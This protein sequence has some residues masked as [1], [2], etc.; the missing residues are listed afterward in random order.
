[1]PRATLL[2]TN[3]VTLGELLSN[4][5][6][7]A[8]PA[9]QR[10]YSWT[11][12]HWEDLWQDIAAL[13]R[14]ELPH[15]MGAVVLQYGPEAFTVIDGQ[16]RLATLS[17]LALA[18]LRVL[19][20]LR[21]KESEAETI[22][23][24][25]RLLREQFVGGK[26]PASLRYSSKLQLNE[27]DNA[28]YQ[29]VLVQQKEPLNLRKLTTSERLLWNALAFFEKRL[30][31]S[32]ASRLQ[33]EA[34]A[35]FLN[36]L[37][38]GRL[39]FIEIRVEDDLSA[40]T[41][42][43]TLNARG[44]ELTEAD[45]LKN[46][47]FSLLA[48]SRLDLEHAREQWSRISRQVS[49]RD[50]PL[51]LRHYLNS[52]QRYVRRE[53]VFRALKEKVAA[54]EQ[55]FDLLQDLERLAYLY[56]ALDAPDDELWLDY[57]GCREEVRLLGLFRVSQYKP[58]ALACHE[59]LGAEDF[60]GVLHACVIVSF[61]FNVVGRRSTHILEEVFNEAAMKVASGEIRD[62]RGVRVALRNAY[63]PDEEFRTDFESA[64]FPARQH[65]KLVR[66]ILARMERH[67]SGTD[68][69]DETMTATVEHILPE[70]P[71]EGWDD[72][73]DEDR[74]R[75]T[76]R[77]GN[78]TLLE[79]GLNREA[80]RNSLDVKV[81]LYQQSQYQLTK[82]VAGEVWTPATIQHR[83]K[84]MARWASAIWRLD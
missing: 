41:V 33:G 62:A 60:R 78:L 44:L 30:R 67:L 77:L 9:Y 54:R 14:S 58:L 55:A 72:F 68:L 47:L 7:Y 59:R 20:S 81:R 18:A 3:T 46:Y 82:R 56:A 29:Q 66:Y 16:Q 39:V 80:G 15:Y 4:G 52:R 37:V 24:R 11:E 71:H 36:G 83:Q 1:M 6:R 48:E 84:E 26:D 27:N 53:R 73:S 22:D 70:N 13:E 38:A 75:L 43:E 76:W 19:S 69:N 63:V 10:D 12:E 32:F 64:A 17:I 74:A 31:E 40:Y 8:V 21:E 79:S 51:F 34:I 65:K 23:E 42:F 61:R 2:E 35:A 45:L 49:A 50:L 5:K 28:F 57:P 25:I